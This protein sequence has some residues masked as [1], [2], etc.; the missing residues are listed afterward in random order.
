MNGEGIIPRKEVTPLTIDAQYVPGFTWARQ[1][2]FRIVK[3]FDKK[4]WLG[5]SV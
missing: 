3:D 2:Q 5:L 1:P 4:F